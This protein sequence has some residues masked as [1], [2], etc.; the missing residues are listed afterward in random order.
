MRYKSCA[1]PLLRHDE[2]NGLT[3]GPIAKDLGRNVRKA[4]QTDTLGLFVLGAAVTTPIGR[5]L[6][7]INFGPLEEVGLAYAG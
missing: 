7:M 3:R 5:L 2:V 6:L 4:A 1:K